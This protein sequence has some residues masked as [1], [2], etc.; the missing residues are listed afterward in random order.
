MKTP[1]YH[2]FRSAEAKAKYLAL[3]DEAAKDWPIPSEGRMVDTS[4]GQT[5]VRIS[6]PVDAPPLVLLPGAGCCSL[7][8]R[9]NIEALSQ[10]HRTYA[11][12]TLINIG[13][14][15]RSV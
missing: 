9:L 11:V 12:D 5:F 10:R 4:Y 2:P 14:V 3:Y 8:W 7:M 15:G 13:C 6:G 1:A